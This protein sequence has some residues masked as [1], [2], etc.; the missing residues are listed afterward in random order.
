MLITWLLSLLIWIPIIGGIVVLLIGR[1][2]QNKRTA[3]T[4]AL[5]FAVLTLG[6]CLP[7]YSGFNV[8]DYHMQFV[9]N[10]AWIPQLGIRYSLGVDGISVLEKWRKEKKKLDLFYQ[11]KLKLALIRLKKNQICL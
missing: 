6:L 8:N 3:R 2:D 4:V 5:I 1:S 7:L 11:N 10:F 9:E